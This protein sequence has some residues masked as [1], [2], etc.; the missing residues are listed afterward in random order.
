[1]EKNQLM[2]KGSIVFIGILTII[3]LYVISMGIINDGL[4]KTE[5]LL[6]AFVLLAILIDN[7]L[8]RSKKKGFTLLLINALI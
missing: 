4:S 3:M 6:Q 2:K 7:F 1:M 8:S 5:N